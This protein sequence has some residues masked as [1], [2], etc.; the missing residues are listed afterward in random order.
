MLALLAAC[1][2]A[3]AATRWGDVET[4]RRDANSFGALVAM[5]ARGDSL[6]MWGSAANRIAYSWRPAGGDWGPTRTAA[7]GGRMTGLDMRMSPFG[8]AVVAWSLADRVVVASARPGE[9]LSERE[10]IAVAGAE[11]LQLRVDDAG[12]ALAGWSLGRDQEERDIR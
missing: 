9:A 3:A 12:D 10:R 1:G 8:E 2:P 4:V 11:Q 6:A 5:D 7:A